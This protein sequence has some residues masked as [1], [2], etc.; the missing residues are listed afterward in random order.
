MGVSE[1]DTWVAKMQQVWHDK[2]PFWA[3]RAKAKMFL[4]FAGNSDVINVLQQLTNGPVYIINRWLMTSVVSLPTTFYAVDRHNKS[5][6]FN[7]RKFFESQ[8]H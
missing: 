2:C 3:Q 4:P 7:F 8:N 5:L 1:S 6:I